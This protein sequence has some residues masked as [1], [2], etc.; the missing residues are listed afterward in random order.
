[1]GMGDHNHL[2][3]K[4]GCFDGWEKSTLVAL[5]LRPF[6]GLR[7]TFEGVSLGIVDGQ[8][9]APV[10][11]DETLWDKPPSCGLGT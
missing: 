9:S 5:L 1:M 3:P 7:H 8:I 4:I 2:A 10:G 6:P 11:M